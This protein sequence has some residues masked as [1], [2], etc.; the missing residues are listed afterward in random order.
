[1]IQSCRDSMRTIGRTR[2]VRVWVSPWLSGECYN[3]RNIIRDIIQIMNVRHFGGLLTSAT[4]VR[5]ST[6]PE[7]EMIFV[8]SYVTT[9]KKGLLERGRSRM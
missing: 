5:R 2:S 3:C 6:A 8:N 4:R 1:M 9:A 7:N